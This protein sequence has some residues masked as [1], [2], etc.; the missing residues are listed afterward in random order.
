MN[1]PQKIILPDGV[2]PIDCDPL[3]PAGAQN[4]PMNHVCGYLTNPDESR[5]L[6][7]NGHYMTGCQSQGLPQAGHNVCSA[8]FIYYVDLK[9]LNC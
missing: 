6:D 2:I 3:A 1:L 4:C 9:M 5:M 8:T 7:E